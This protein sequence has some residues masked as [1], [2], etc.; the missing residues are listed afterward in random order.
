MMCP[1]IC[2]NQ[3]CNNNNNK[4]HSLKNNMFQNKGRREEPSVRK[5]ITLGPKQL[6]SKYVIFVK[7]FVC[8]VRSKI[9]NSKASQKMKYFMKEIVMSIISKWNYPNMYVRV[10]T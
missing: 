1:K 2:Q 4:I 8:Q 10:R 7:D 6:S 5:P 3:I 9:D